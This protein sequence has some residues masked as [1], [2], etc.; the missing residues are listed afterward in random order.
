MTNVEKILAYIMAATLFVTFACDICLNIEDMRIQEE[1]REQESKLTNI[2]KVYTVEAQ[3]VRQEVTVRCVES[4]DAA[5]YLDDTDLSEEYQRYCRDVADKYSL[6]PYIL[7]AMVERE[8]NGKADACNLEG[9]SGLLQ[10][11]PRWHRERMKRLGVTDLSDPYSNILVAADYL[12]ELLEDNGYNL[13]L[14][15]MKYNM[16]HERAEE[17][18][19]QGIYSDYASS[20]IRRGYELRFLKEGGEADDE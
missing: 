1:I 16:N 9:D 3:P 13:P 6:D 7:M 4:Y 5:S 15:L 10:V 18:V 8:S 2:E 19:S 12:H 17:L 20:V 11:N 14:A